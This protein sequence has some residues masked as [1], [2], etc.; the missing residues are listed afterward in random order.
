MVEKTI[1]IYIQEGGEVVLFQT[2]REL[3]EMMEEVG[4]FYFDFTPYCG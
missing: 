3:K 4:K 1:E 2:L